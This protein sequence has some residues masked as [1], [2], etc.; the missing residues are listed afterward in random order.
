MV[1]KKSDEGSFKMIL[2][3]T[4]DFIRYRGEKGKS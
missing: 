4:V 2:N 1:H 3:L